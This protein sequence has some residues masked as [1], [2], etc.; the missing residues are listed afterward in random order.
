MMMMMSPVDIH[1]W[2]K[3][4]CLLEQKSDRNYKE[5][6]NAFGMLRLFIKEF[7]I[8]YHVNVVSILVSVLIRQVGGSGPVL[9]VHDDKCFYRRLNTS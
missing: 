6:M 2:V 5:G 7:Y 3:L 8:L 4:K 9:T 1:F